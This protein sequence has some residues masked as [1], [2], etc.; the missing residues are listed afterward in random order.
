MLLVAVTGPVGSEKTTIV[1]DFAQ[2]AIESGATVDGF[3]SIAGIRRRNAEGAES[4]TLHWFKTGERELFT[5]RDED[6]HFQ[7]EASTLE[8]LADWSKSVEPKQDLIVLDEFGKWEAT[9]GGI[10]PFWAGVAA[11][12]PRMVVVTLREGVRD[13]IEKQLG[14]KFDRVL[15][16]DVADTKDQLFA[17]FAELK[18]WEMVGLYGASSGAIE[19]SLGNW[20]HAIRFPFVGTV[21]GSLQAA[22]LAMASSQVGRKELIVWISTIAAGLKAISPGRGR[23]TPVVAI[24]VQGFLFVIGASLGRWTKLGFAIGAF[25]VGLWAVLQS[26]FIQYLFIGRALQFSFDSAAVYLSK[27]V[28]VKAISM[29][30]FVAIMCVLNGALSVF[31][32]LMTISRHREGLT[33][34]MAKASTGDKSSS[35]TRTLSW[36]P[37]VFIIGVLFFT[38]QPIGEFIWLLLRVVAVSL[39]LYGL[40]KL[41]KRLDYTKL[42]ARFGLWGPAVA[43][44]SA[45]EK[46]SLPRE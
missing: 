25:L 34:L 1:R 30:V 31:V 43:M 14:R 38:R 26:F 13:E 12:K 41:M 44:R 2:A 3:V 18:D 35:A 40:A 28:G 10:M 24:T 23:I 11:S 21:M 19:C 29:W 46:S 42:F 20:L 33:K 39:S 7:T 15:E 9:G 36:L 32:T 27:L 4:Y 8:H 45:A 16:A 17:M 22:V 37:L 6:G 5:S